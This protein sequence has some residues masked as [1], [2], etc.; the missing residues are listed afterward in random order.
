M[1]STSGTDYGVRFSSGA[2]GVLEA[3]RW[4][5]F[6]AGASP[7]VVKLW[8]TT[9]SAVVYTMTAGDL[10]PFAEAGAGWKLAPLAAPPA[11][12]A[13]REYI[14]AATGDG[15]FAWA[16]RT[17]STPVP[18]APLTVVANI[19]HPAAGGAM[20]VTTSLNAYFLDA[21]V[22]TGTTGAPA[23]ASGAVRLPNGTAGA[24][25]WRNAGNTADLALTV[26]SGNALTFD[27]NPVAVGNF[28]PLT[29]GTLTGDLVVSEATPTVS[30]KQAAD[31]QPRSRLTDTALSFGPGG[32]TAPDATL[33]RTG[34]GALRADTQLGVGA[35]PGAGVPFVVGTRLSVGSTGTLTVT[36]DAGQP[37]L[38]AGNLALHGVTG[39]HPQVR[40]ESGASLNLVGTSG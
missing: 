35:T 8:D 5:R 17:S 21:Q 29:G 16:R 22:L 36:P 28:L 11:L 23:A 26:S 14:L 30:L 15:S 40:A 2:A 24:V 1:G 18:D 31:T 34:A 27:G 20:P 13:G 9:T 38:V 3:V 25:A 6:S 7:T 19:A 32:S 37:S 33:S 4:Y 12:V 39:G 10:T